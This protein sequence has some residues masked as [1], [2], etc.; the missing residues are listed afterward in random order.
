MATSIEAVE[1]MVGKVLKHHP[2]YKTKTGDVR[3]VC[4]AMVF[5]LAPTDDQ[6][7]DADLV[8]I[9]NG[10][11]NEDGS[12]STTYDPNVCIATSERALISKWNGHYVE[13]ITGVDVVDECGWR[14]SGP[15][16]NWRRG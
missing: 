7:Y 8:R 4:A 9:F 13:N 15:G 1:C 3:A 16:K 11:K 10:F 6:N 14:N 5:G 12:T 2:E